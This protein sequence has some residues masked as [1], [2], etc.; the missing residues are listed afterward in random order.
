MT[1]FLSRLKGR[2]IQR[3]HWFIDRLI[4][5]YYGVETCERVPVEQLQPRHAKDRQALKKGL[6]KPYHPTRYLTLKNLLK[7]IPINPKNYTFIDLGCGKGRGLLL[8]QKKGYQKV[9]G[10]EI[11]QNLYHQ[12]MHNFR[13]QPPNLSPKIYC[14]NVTDYPIPQGN[15]VIF[16]F[17]PFGPQII[18]QVVTSLLNSKEPDEDI[19]I[20]Y[21]N[22]TYSKSWH[23]GCQL[24][25]VIKN[26]DPNYRV[27]IFQMKSPEDQQTLGLLT[28][29]IHDQLT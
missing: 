19:W 5:L 3:Y 23:Q 15:K 10:I 18:R 26:A 6:A 14:R 25:K 2:I 17:N 13:R 4:D 9:V 8:A 12:A 21:V 22:P 29:E 27:H 20:A 24:K 11:C 16:L 7:S 1:R 28:H